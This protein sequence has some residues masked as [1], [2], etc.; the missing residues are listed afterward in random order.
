MSYQEVTKIKNK[1]RRTWN[2]FFGKFGRLLPI[3]VKSIPIVL[4]GEN[5]VISSS[6]A[7]GK[8]EAVVAPIIERF[9]KEKWE[10]LAILYISPTRALVNDLSLRLKEQLKELNVSLS[11]KTGDRRQF[12]P[13]KPSSFLITTP[14]SFDSLLCRYPHVLKNIKIVILD[15]IHLLDN[16]YRGDQLILLLRRLKNILK[17]NF[18]I[19]CL[20]ATIPDCKELGERYIQKFEVIEALGNREIDYSLIKSFGELLKFVRSEKLKKLLVFC[21]KR[22]SVEAYTIECNKLKFPFKAVAHHGSLGKSLR[23]D[24]ERFMK[25]TKYGICVSTMTLEIGIDI[26]NIDAI[27]LAEIPW[28]VSSLLQ[29]IGRGN[30]RTNKIRAFAIFNS[31]EQKGI[32]DQMFKF[33][34]EGMLEN[35]PYSADLSVVVQQIVS[36]LYGNPGGLELEFFLNLFINFC[37]N[38][39]LRDIFDNLEIGDWVVKKHDK[40]CG[41]T[42]L[43]DFGDSGF[44]H[45]N[46]PDSRSLIVIDIK[47]KKKIGEILY[48]VDNVFVLG[49]KIWK[50]AKIEKSKIYVK[51]VVSKAFLPNFKINDPIG[52]FYYYLPPHLRKAEILNIQETSN[53]SANEVG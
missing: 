37:F 50:I 16:T 33:A 32:L 35:I 2:T 42:K 38:N 39:D 6:T 13:N 4:S 25:T 29:R 24:S 9:L 19:Y 41:T 8:T 12:T 14:E 26:G 31:E 28:T 51:P 1:L 7:S 34:I 40:W 43:M 45:S 10:G 5:A 49:G 36:C 11:V 46:I 27:V 18:S 44:I 22:K 53:D 20:S 47:S 52:K 30:R 15:E 21:N 17:S 48:P 3:Q 23:E